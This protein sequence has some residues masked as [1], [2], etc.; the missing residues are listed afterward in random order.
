MP[1]AVNLMSKKF[2]FKFAE[3]NSALNK[4]VFR[5]YSKTSLSEVKDVK[6]TFKQVLILF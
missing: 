4:V 1:K 2:V 3:K 5:N 6:M